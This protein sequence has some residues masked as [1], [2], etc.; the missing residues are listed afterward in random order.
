[1]PH[2][3]RGCEDG[4]YSTNSIADLGAGAGARRLFLGV[5]I[6]CLTLRDTVVA[7]G[8]AIESGRSAKGGR[9][10]QHV[11]LNV[12]KFV[13]MRANPELD[14][15]VRSSDIIS[16]DGMGIVWGARLLG[17]DV[18][19]RVTGVDVMEGVI[20][21]CAERGYRPYF[22]GARPEVLERAVAKT[23]SRH[24]GLVF[25]GWRDG[26]YRPDEEDSVVAEIDAAG[27]DCLFIGMPTPRK[28]RFLARRRAALRVP[29]IMGVGGG[30]DVLAGEVR[31]A[32]ASVQN[33]GLEWLFRAVQ[34]PLRLG[35]RYA[36][37]N[38]AFAAILASALWES[39]RPRT[40]RPLG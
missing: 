36:K 40:R 39:R 26:Y 28:E 27:A 35:P 33:L 23:T 14:S 21:L 13:A 15:D 29:F 1:M 22:L 11:C 7:A 25:A 5:P 10:L 37:T 18:P 12:A 19:E 4:A 30:L 6:D 20:G 24:P 16:V 38:L 32:P 9:A 34:E 31:R 3:M 17:V 8:R 2:D